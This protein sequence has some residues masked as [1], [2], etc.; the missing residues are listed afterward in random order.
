MAS[1]T[2]SAAGRSLAGRPSRRAG[3]DRR[4]VEA[5]V[6]AELVTSGNAATKAA[7]QALACSSVA[8]VAP[9]P[10]R[11]AVVARAVA[12][13]I[14]AGQQRGVRRQRDRRRRVGALEQRA[15]LRQRVE[16]AVRARA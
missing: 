4:R 14:T 16:R 11:A 6:E 13:R 9:T 3:S 15:A 7:S 8:S 2:T 1:L 5:A 12:G 10:T